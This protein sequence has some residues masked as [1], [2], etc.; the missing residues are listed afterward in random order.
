[1]SSLRLA[2]YC[3]LTAL[4]LLVSFLVLLTALILCSA[5]YCSVNFYFPL[6]RERVLNSVFLGNLEK[7][8]VSGFK[9][10]DLSFTEVETVFR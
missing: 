8:S 3:I 6:L 2:V 4:A 10:Y 5:K 7:C 1:M 9:I